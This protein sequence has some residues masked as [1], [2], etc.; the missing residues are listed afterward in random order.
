MAKQTIN[1]GTTANDG[2]GDDLRDAFI[3]V[4]DNFTELYTGNV[5]LLGSNFT[6]PQVLQVLLQN[7][8]L[9]VY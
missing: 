7:L 4:N 6:T 3:K 8:Y 2:T 9:Q 5:R 1:T